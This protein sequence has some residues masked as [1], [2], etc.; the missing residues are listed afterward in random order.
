MG[1]KVSEET[2]RAVRLYQAGGISIAA[3]AAKYGILPTTLYRALDRAG[4]RPMVKTAVKP[5]M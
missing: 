5:Q 4:I 3:A 1:A 2:K